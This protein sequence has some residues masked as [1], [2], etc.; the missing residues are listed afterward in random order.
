M[1]A[2]HLRR[3]RE[4]SYAVPLHL[5]TGTRQAIRKD[6]VGRCCGSHHCFTHRQLGRREIVRLF[7]YPI[8]F[9][10]GGARAEFIRFYKYNEKS[11]GTRAPPPGPARPSLSRTV[12]YR[13]EVIHA[14]G[15]CASTAPA[16]E[17]DTQNPDPASSRLR[18]SP[19]QCFHRPPSTEKSLS[20]RIFGD[21]TTGI[22][23]PAFPC[24]TAA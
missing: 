13:T 7:L 6:C 16:L 10:R 12:W 15:R 21:S 1:L 5:A 8:E 4:A 23:F 20:K 2:V 19:A 3:G 14:S 11:L 17:T 9:A 18:I 22:L 24:K